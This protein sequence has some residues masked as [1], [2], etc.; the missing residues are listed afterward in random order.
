M[1]LDV[2]NPIHFSEAG[3]MSLDPVDSD[4][5]GERIQRAFPAARV[6]KSLNTVTAR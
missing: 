2:A 6:V 1:L 3:E 4:S 5:L